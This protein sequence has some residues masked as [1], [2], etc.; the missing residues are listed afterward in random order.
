VG[1][2]ADGRIAARVWQAGLKSGPPQALKVR[3][4]LFGGGTGNPIFG[5]LGA[6]GE[7]E[8]SVNH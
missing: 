2:V 7:A 6:I 3:E 4:V 5:R 1:Y 8:V